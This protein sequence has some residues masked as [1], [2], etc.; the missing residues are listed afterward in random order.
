MA[1]TERCNFLD[2]T[3]GFV[4]MQVEPDVDF[5]T[6]CKC[7]LDSGIKISTSSLLKCVDLYIRVL[8]LCKDAKTE[9]DIKSSLGICICDGGFIR[10]D[11]KYMDKEYYYNGSSRFNIIDAFKILLDDTVNERNN[12]ERLKISK[13]EIEVI[14][15]N[16]DYIITLID[17][18]IESLM[19]SFKEHISSKSVRLIYPIMTLDHTNETMNRLD[20]DYY[21]HDYRELNLLYIESNFVR[22]KID[23]GIS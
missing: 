17:S 13:S 22:P 19:K 1:E 12:E 14:K 23:G 10:T 16:A 15:E 6:I 5:Y 18:F 7:V 21:Y 4:D 20:F 3:C 8:V 11:I 2:T 9:N